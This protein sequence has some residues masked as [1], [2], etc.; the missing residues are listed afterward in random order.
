MIFSNWAPQ[1]WHL[2]SKIGISF[3]LLQYNGCPPTIQRGGG[4]SNGVIW[5]AIPYKTPCGSEVPSLANDTTVPPGGLRQVRFWPR[6][7]AHCFN[8]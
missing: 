8:L 1:S 2:Y 4:E 5:N 3:S 7:Q 6:P